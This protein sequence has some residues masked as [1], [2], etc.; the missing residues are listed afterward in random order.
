MQA[1]A[2]G[3]AVH[4]KVDEELDIS[5]IPV[6]WRQCPRLGTPIWRLIPMKV[7]LDSKFNDHI[8]QEDRFSVKDAH[9]MV[10]DMLQQM[11]APTMPDGTALQPSCKL[12]IDLTN[13]S[14][15]YDAAAWHDLGVHHVKVGGFTSHAWPTLACTAN[16]RRA[17]PHHCRHPTPAT[18]L[19]WRS[20]PASLTCPPLFL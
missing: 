15:Y 6:G 7:P 12:V 16:I 14:R 20:L 18:A 17:A 19:L 5:G 11:K 4:D 3:T 1:L 8:A 13:S 2:P 10:T 9:R